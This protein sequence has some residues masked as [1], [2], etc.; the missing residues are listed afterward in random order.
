MISIYTETKS[1]VTQESAPENTKFALRLV[2]RKPGAGY[3]WGLPWAQGAM[4][5]RIGIQ[6]M[7]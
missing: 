1:L 2:A 5:S 6:R 7:R 4:I 3:N